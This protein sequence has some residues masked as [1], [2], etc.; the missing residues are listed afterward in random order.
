MAKIKCVF[1]VADIHIRNFMR[2]EEYSDQLEAFINE[3]SKIASKYDE[4]EV[5]I[6]ICGDIAHNKNSVSNELFSFMSAFIR[7]LEEIAPVIIFSGNH[8]LLI[9]NTQRKDTIS[10]LFDTANFQNSTFLDG[11]LD[12]ESGIIVDNNITW[13]LYS[14]FDDFRKPDIESARI[15][16]P[17]NTVVGLYHGTIV[18]ASLNNG[19]VLDSGVDGDIFKGCDIVMAGDIH[20]RQVLKRGN[21]KI[22]YPG[23]LIQQTFGETVT[24]HGFVVWDIENKKHEFFDIPSEYSLYDFSIKNVEDLDSDK[25]TLINY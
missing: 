23:S 8:D 9:G 10:A 11:Y 3:V 25:E 6:V 19:M 18:G 16:N 14:I 12:Y 17:D 22:V 2:L 7:R 20:K 4:G 5:R 24:Q 15:N 1:Q 21:V 13:A